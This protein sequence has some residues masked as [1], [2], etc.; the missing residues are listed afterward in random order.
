[1]VELAAKTALV[2]EPGTDS[3]YS[4]AGF[5]VLARVLEL[6]GGKPYAQL[7]AEH[8]LSPAGM[9]DTS[10]VGTRAILERRAES[11]GPQRSSHQGSDPQ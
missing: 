5:S 1:M 10:D 9:A 8:V 4:S 6:A 2:F 11:F 7:L 3:V